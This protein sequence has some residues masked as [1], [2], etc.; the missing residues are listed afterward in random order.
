[1]I[2][3]RKDLAAGNPASSAQDEQMEFELVRK[4]DLSD[5]SLS[6]DQVTELCSFDDFSRGLWLLGLAIIETNT[7]SIVSRQTSPVDPRLLPLP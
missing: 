7:H 5:L 4:G 6:K 3:S 2:Y 1:M